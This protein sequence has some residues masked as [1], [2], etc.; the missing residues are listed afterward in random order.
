M[1]VDQLQIYC[2]KHKDAIKGFSVFRRTNAR[3]MK[4]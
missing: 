4:K 2:I 3:L 1:G